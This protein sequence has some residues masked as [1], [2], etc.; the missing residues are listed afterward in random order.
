MLSTITAA[1]PMSNMN[2]FQDAMASEKHSYSY[3][4]S[5]EYEKLLF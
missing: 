3:D 1:I 4:N 2:L 5:R